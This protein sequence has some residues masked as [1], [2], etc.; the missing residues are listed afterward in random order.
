MDEAEQQG[1]STRAKVV[2]ALLAGLIVFALM[3]HWGGGIDTQPPVCYSMFGWYTVPCDA[4][5]SWAAGA[6]TA[7]VVFLALL[8]K[9]RRR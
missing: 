4:W 9:D 8:R 5:V 1:T 3:F 2:V 6:A 7:G